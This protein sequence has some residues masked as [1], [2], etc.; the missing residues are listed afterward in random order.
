[1]PGD[2]PAGLSPSLSALGGS[3]FLPKT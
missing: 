2:Q 1:M 3:R